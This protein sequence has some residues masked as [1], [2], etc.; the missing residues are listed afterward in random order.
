M[1][2]VRFVWS[3][4]GT[5]VISLMILAQALGLLVNLMEVLTLPSLAGA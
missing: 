5:H 1:D 3:T 2:R 4:R